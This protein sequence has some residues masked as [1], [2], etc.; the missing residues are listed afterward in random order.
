MTNE[1]PPS[2]ITYAKLVEW[3]RDD[4]I[5]PEQVAPYMI[6]VPSPDG[7]IDPIFQPNPSLVTDIDRGLEG[8]FV[9]GLFNQKYRKKRLKDYR[10]RL[11]AGWNGLRIVDEGD[12]WFQYPKRLEDIIDHVMHTYPVYSLS[13]AGHTLEQM[14]KQDEVFNVVES[15]KADALLLSAGGNDLFDNGKLGELIEDVRPGMTA[16]QLVGPRFDSFVR[17]I[18]SDYRRLILRFHQSF[19]GLAILIH[20]YSGAFSQMDR[21]IGKPLDDKGVRPV[22]VQN[23]VVQVMVQKF[24]AAQKEMAADPVF[25][26]KLVHVDLTGL[27]KNQFEWFDE[28]HMASAANKAAASLFVQAIKQNAQ[29]GGLESGLETSAALPAAEVPVT[30]ISAHAVELSAL[31]EPALM[32][33]LQLRLDR[34]ERH[35]QS[36]DLPSSDLLILAG[37]LEGGSFPAVGATAQRL[38]RRWERELFI[39]MCGDNDSDTDERDKLREALGVSPDALIGA[40][41]AWLAVGPLGVPALLAGVLAAILV[42]RFGGAAVEELCEVWRERLA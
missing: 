8:G 10:E 40:L 12:S 33:E 2:K 36:G 34:I 4:E 26:G 42:K 24:N 15:E 27:A 5:P 39:L 14:I 17:E 28:I 16:H 6:H 7:S 21:W 18:L 38:L 20:G 23:R 29:P 30:A 11:A 32:A 41:S 13:G 22:A 31:D 37:G 19:P 35:P 1:N 3:L 25:G 9:I